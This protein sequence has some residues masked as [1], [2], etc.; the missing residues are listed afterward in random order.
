MHSRASKAD[1]VNELYKVLKIP[2]PNVYPP[3]QQIRTAKEKGKAKARA[4]SAS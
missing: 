2:N 3:P 1:Y 4:K